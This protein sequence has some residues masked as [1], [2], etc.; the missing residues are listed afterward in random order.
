MAFRAGVPIIGSLLW[1]EENARPQWRAQRLDEKNAKPAPVPIRYGRFSTKRG[2]YAMVFSKLCYRHRDLGRGVIVPF[3]RPIATFD[4]LQQ[5]AEFLA[6]AEGL[7]GNWEWG[8]VGL[9]KNTSS[10]LPVDFVERWR[11]FFRGKAAHFQG[12]SGHTP[13]E[14]PA[15]AE[16]G[17]LNLKWPITGK[18][19]PK[20]D[21]LLATPTKART[22]DHSYLKRYPR[23]TE[24]GSLVPNDAT[25]YFMRNVLHGIR[26]S[27]DTS[28]WKTVKR[29]YPRFA[30]EWPR[31]D[32]SL[33][34]RV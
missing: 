3:V 31:I 6:T 15:I 11:R 32:S 4:D 27:E 10:K 19:F 20:Y 30:A 8:A 22:Q 5:E 23:P 29:L 33:S 17:F 13:S 26:T 2:A 16:D 24:I 7:G 12:F 21:L 28:I 14:T 9:L 25:N 34:A 18:G 1:D